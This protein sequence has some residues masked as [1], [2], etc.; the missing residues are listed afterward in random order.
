MQS[1]T[2]RGAFKQHAGGLGGHRRKRIRLGTRRFERIRSSKP[3]D[4][5]IVLGLCVV[6][7]KIGIAD[8]PIGKSS[9]AHIAIQAPLVKVTLM[10]SPVIG[11]EMDSATAHLPSVFDC[12]E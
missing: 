3:G 8:G 10:K 11:R 12:L 2:F 9:A 1:E 6:G 7:L 5:E 4:S